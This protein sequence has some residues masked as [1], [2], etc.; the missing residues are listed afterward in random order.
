ML[1][2]ICK[3]ALVK[4]ATSEI[5]LMRTKFLQSPSKNLDEC[6]FEYIQICARE[7]HEEELYGSH[8]PSEYYDVRISVID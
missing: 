4:L 1:L 6:E 8:G 7:I 2:L 5:K 3:L